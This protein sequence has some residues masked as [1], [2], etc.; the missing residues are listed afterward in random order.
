MSKSSQLT[1][2]KLKSPKDVEMIFQD[3]AK[4]SKMLDK[5]KAKRLLIFQIILMISIG[6]I[7]VAN[8]FERKSNNVSFWG[9]IVL[10]IWQS[11]NLY[12][13][14]KKYRSL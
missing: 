13:S 4:R 6:V 10:F 3:Q 11:F 2:A 7:V 14:I 8:I 12:Q 5:K 1:E 9:S